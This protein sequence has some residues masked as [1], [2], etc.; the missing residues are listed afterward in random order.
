MSPF[1][2]KRLQEQ[3]N[4]VILAVTSIVSRTVRYGLK[5]QWELYLCRRPVVM[6]V[7]I[8]FVS[9]GWKV[10]LERVS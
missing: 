3:S 9:Q 4:Q 8:Y 7:Y 5:L 2:F 6:K 1:N 10:S